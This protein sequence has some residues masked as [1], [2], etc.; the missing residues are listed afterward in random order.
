MCGFGI[1]ECGDWVLFSELVG[2]F[3]A[4]CM[5]TGERER[6]RLCTCA[7]EVSGVVAAGCLGVAGVD[8]GDEEGEEG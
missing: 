4:V 6:G 5:W 3:G 7:G 8:G 1:C 2:G